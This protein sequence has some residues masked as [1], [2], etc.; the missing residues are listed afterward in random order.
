MLFYFF[1]TYFCAIHAPATISSRN[2][3]IQGY[4][5]KTAIVVPVV[6]RLVRISLVLVGFV[7]PLSAQVND[8][9]RTDNTKGLEL[10]PPGFSPR[11][12][13]LS[14]MVVTTPDGYDN[15]DV[16]IDNA[17]QHMSANPNNPLQILFGVNGSGGSTW[18]HT[19]DG[20]LTWATQNPPGTNSG[21]PW[22]AYDS[23]GNAYIQFLQSSN[24][25]VWKSTNNGVTWS[26]GVPSAPGGDRNTMAVDQT[27]GPYGG[28][29][30]AGA[31]FL[32][33][34]DS[35]RFARSTN[36]GASFTVTLTTPNTTPG[37]MIAVGANVLGGQN[38]QGG[39]VY[40]VSITGPNPPG[41]PSTY[42][43]FRSTNGGAS[44]NSM[45]SLTVAG[46]VGTQNTA[47][48]LTI[49]NARTRPYPMI[50][51]DNSNGPYRG[52]L[53]LAYASNEPAGNGNK[54]DI[55]I[56][57]S[58]DQGATWT[59]RSQRINDNVNP[60]T[61]N[62]W[63]PLIWC[64]KNTGRLYAKWYD[65]RDDP[66]N[67]RANVYA[68]F[69]DDGGQ[70]FVPNTKLTN[71][72]MAYPGIACAPNSNCYRGDYD[73]ITSAGD[74]ALA[75]WTDFRNLSRQNM[76]A[77]FPDFAML[78]SQNAALLGPTDS[79]NVFV[80]IPSVKY[81]TGVARFSATVSPAAPFT[82]SFLNGR[83]SLTS[84][85]DSVSLKIRTN[86]VIAGT[87]TVTVTG[88]GRKGTPVHRRT[89]TVVV[90]SANAVAVVSP[91]GGETW[92]SGSQNNITWGRTGVVDSVKIEYSTDNGTS[93]GV[94]SAGVP[95][96][97]ASYSWTA[98][99]IPTTQA[100]VRVSWTD[101]TNVTDGSDGPF[102][103]SSAPGWTAQTSGI[104]NQFYSVKAV[105][106]TAAWA[107]AVGGRV[108]RTTNGGTTWASVGGGAIGTAD[109]Y[110]IEAVD[111]NTAFVTTSPAAT[112]IYR[113]TNGGTSWTQVYT[114]ASTGAFIDVI[115]MFDTNNGIAIGDPVGGK[116]VIVR[117]SDGGA[118]WVRDTTNAPLR[119]GTEAGT[120]ND[121]CTIGSAN[122]W[123]GSTADGRIYRTTNGGTSWL[124]STL[125]GSTAATGAIA[126]W[127]LDTQ[128][129][130]AS[131]VTGTTYNA[132]RTT[133]G[134][135]T[136]SAVTVG[137]TG[138]NI[139]V[140]GSGT[141][142]F[143]MARETAMFRSGDRGATWTQSYTGT[144]IFYDVD[145]RTSGAN[146]YGWAMKDN[147]NIVFFFGSVT[148]VREQPQ[149]TDNVPEAIALMQNY[150]NPFNPSTTIKFRLSRSETV[151]LEVFDITGRRVATL[152]NDRVSEGEHTVVFDAKNLSSGTYGY[153]LNVAGHVLS[154]KMTL[155]K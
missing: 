67:Q 104:T 143:W 30:Y 106:Q 71:A 151:L 129:G 134:G 83:D 50:A 46:W 22:T 45:S 55:F 113:T 121:L 95:V 13:G 44:F 146:T 128:Y 54:P 150:P 25:P 103:I 7:L 52:R 34:T 39:C 40:F 27:N 102:T 62:E 17:E 24:N 124:S 138:F 99:N 145:F 63:F 4:T 18:R 12:P 91:N 43:F 123:F 26:G 10:Y 81:Y 65:M 53:Y 127:F 96:S 89:L 101:S 97:P 135:A 141:T 73:C 78:L 87:Y 37:N 14:L 48:R 11:G 61:T 105:S 56:Q 28:Y 80:K 60:E 29:V 20:G 8:D 115:K 92:T 98:P 117:T 15:F 51:A 75:V 100:R 90:T 9:G 110:N 93:W 36:N 116:W 86:N 118:S 41:A 152:V 82:F 69:S 88:Q 114:D 70:T 5:M 64:D 126:V 85:P 144:G 68:T 122:M 119:V 6:V 140:S 130:I 77:Y 66:T 120:Q 107:A 21:D 16:G 125:P 149:P 94:V 79:T 155:V 59:P 38:I 147:G 2:H 108:L 154:Q 133:D 74:V 76:L 139:A 109:I 132:A 111:A 57:Y 136:W 49:N 112:F 84:Y 142:N 33:N 42:N 131:S 153:T 72:D 23:L 1:D 35:C 19:E 47:G 148:D 31:W 3:I 32:N 58:T 137:T